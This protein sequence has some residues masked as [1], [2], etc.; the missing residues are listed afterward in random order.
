MY[1]TTFISL[2]EC[3]ALFTLDFIYLKVVLRESGGEMVQWRVEAGDGTVFV[4][5]Y[6]FVFFSWISIQKAWKKKWL[7]ERLVLIR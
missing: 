4:F 2:T 1:Y 6:V 5:V 3:Q 7:N